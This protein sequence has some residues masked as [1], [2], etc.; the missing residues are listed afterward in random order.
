MRIGLAAGHSSHPDN[1]ERRRYEHR[2][3]RQVVHCLDTLLGWANHIPILLPSS[4]YLLDNDQSLTSRISYFNKSAPEF[5]VEVHLNSGGGQ[6]STAIYY[7][8]DTGLS[9][10]GRR[11]AGEITGQLTASFPWK[12]IGPRGQRYFGRSLALLNQT[13][14]P[15]VITEAGFKD[16]DDHRQLLDSNEGIVQHA[17]ALFQGIQGYGWSRS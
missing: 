14:M 17:A 9:E 6:Y 11:L 3:C 8:T 16:N 7:D 5:V 1:P 15:A 13:K 10:A 12:T 4:C 2:I